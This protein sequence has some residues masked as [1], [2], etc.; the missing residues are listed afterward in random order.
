MH[1]VAVFHYSLGP[2]HGTE[3]VATYDKEI[4]L[5]SA[6]SACSGL[7]CHRETA[8]T[9]SYIPI[10]VRFIFLRCAKTGS[11]IGHRQSWC[12]VLDLVGCFKS[13]QTRIGGVAND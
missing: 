1:I 3:V 9:T 2:K 13:P 8:L 6:T 12:T 7:G 11:K 10:C 4:D 5:A